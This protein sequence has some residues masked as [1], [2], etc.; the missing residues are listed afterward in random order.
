MLRQLQRL[1]VDAV[2]D[3]HNVLRSWIIDLFFLLKGRR[4]KMLQKQRLGRRHTLGTSH[5]EAPRFTERYFDVF[6]R[7][8]L[9]A[10]P[11]FTSLYDTLPPLPDGI[12]EKQEGEHWIGVAPFARYQN[13]IYPLE[14]MRK[15]V[16]IV[17]GRPHTRVLLF[18]AKGDEA[19]VLEQ[20]ATQIPHTESLAGRYPLTDELA[21]M[22]RLDTMLT[23]DSSNMH[24]ASLTGTRV[25][26]VWGGTT[27]ACGFLGWQQHTED[28]LCAQLPCQ[29]C[30]I[31][32]SEHCPKGDYPCMHAI[33]P[34]TIA[35][36]L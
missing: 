4:V 5:T 19:R 26:S 25:V 12:T 20:W 9:S 32:G 8:G 30:T 11:L 3:L 2:A 14:K 16:E 36:R 23:M 7:L 28:A 27:P 24:L 31:A 34:E 22:T 21:I 6:T 10:P 33:S 15:V 13:K 29:P 17:T 1:E 35:N 18:G